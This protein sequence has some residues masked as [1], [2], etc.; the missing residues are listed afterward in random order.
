MN[1]IPE[2]R[3]QPAPIR[4]DAEASYARLAAIYD[5]EVKRMQPARQRAIHALELQPGMR[6][7][8]VGCGTGLSLPALSAGVGRAG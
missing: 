6:V 1:R 8:D 2:S 4:D 5:E 7:L 3:D